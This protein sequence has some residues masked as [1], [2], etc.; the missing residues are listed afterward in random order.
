M[1]GLV[2]CLVLAALTINTATAAN[3]GKF[4]HV[5]SM[6]AWG[7][8]NLITTNIQLQSGDAVP[9]DDKA[10]AELK[11][12]FPQALAQTHGHPELTAALKDYYAA[13]RSLFGNLDPQAGETKLVYSARISMLETKVK[14]ADSRIQV[15]L[16]SLGVTD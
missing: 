12:E 15:E 5:Q 6:V 2:A 10:L 3:P 8:M 13:S 9:N 4:N 1:R 16:A 11:E 14:E 7:H